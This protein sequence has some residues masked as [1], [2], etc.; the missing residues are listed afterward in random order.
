MRRA[1]RGQ[2]VVHFFY[3][4]KLSREGLEI[5]NEMGVATTASFVVQ[6]ENVTQNL[7]FGNS[8]MVNN[9]TY[10]KFAKFYNDISHISCL[11]ENTKSLLEEHN[12]TS[13]VHVIP[14]G[15]TNSY[16]YRRIEKPERFQ[17]R[18]VI[19]MT[20]NFSKEKDQETLI[21]AVKLSKYSK[22][23]H[24]ILAGEGVEQEKYEAE[25]N[26]LHLQYTMNHYPENDLRE[27]IL[28][29]KEYEKN[30][31]AIDKNNQ[32]DIQIRNNEIIISE[33]R[34]SKENNLGWINQNKAKIEEFKERIS[35]REIIIEKIQSEE[36]LIK[37]WKI[38][39]DMVGKNGISKMVLRKTLPIINAR[40]AQLLSDV[41]DFDVEVTINNRNDIMFNLIKDGVVSDL[42]S[43]SG[44]ERTCASLAL[45]FVL[46]DI[47][48]IPKMNF[49]L[50]DECLGR[51]AKDNLDNIHKLFDKMLTS[52]DFI[53][54]VCHL[55]EAKD[56]SKT[57]I[58]VNKSEN[59][60]HINVEKNVYAK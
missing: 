33:K 8:K 2:D 26:K 53:L 32:L 43:G 60:S 27:M 39:L 31:Q 50:I 37:N 11:S 7:G 58:Y 47:S 54:H 5:A 10:S 35:E 16:H 52:Y 12:Y 36:K 45:R 28:K 46:A 14:N 17:E 4:F 19:T 18:I 38:Y 57:Q 34:R 24:L 1:I 22:Y 15:V 48:S 44:F 40:L 51:V 21:K 25:L 59:I 49:T 23:I 20:G 3:P 56:W 9:M 55:D 13:N 41:C 42:S 6:P 30:A 29:R